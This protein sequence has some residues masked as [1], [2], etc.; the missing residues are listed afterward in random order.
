MNQKKTLL[1]VAVAL[2]VL[3]AGAGVLYRS[4]SAQVEADVLVSEPQG[5]EEEPPARD[6][7]EAAAAAAYYSEMR[8]GE[9]VPVDY[10]RVKNVKKPSGA[11]P[12]KVIYTT[13][14]TAYVDPKKPE[15]L[16]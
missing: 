3:L 9:K 5:P 12:G 7:T 13:N 1:I 11:V 2:V 10:T 4:L 14:Y 8:D 16:R 15:N 6:F